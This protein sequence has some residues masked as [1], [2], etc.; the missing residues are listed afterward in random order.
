MEEVRQARELWESEG[1]DLSESLSTELWS[2]VQG[3]FDFTE[4]N[5]AQIYAVAY[6]PDRSVHTVYKIIREANMSRA[7]CYSDRR[8]ETLAIW[9]RIIE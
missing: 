4:N 1:V 2:R 9:E 8:Q 7:S 5:L 3:S 6:E